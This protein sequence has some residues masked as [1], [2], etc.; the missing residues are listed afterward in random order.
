MKTTETPIELIVPYHRNN[1]THSSTQVDRIARSIKEY[2]FNQ[3][4]VCDKE[5]VIIVGH[6]RLEA[7]KQLGLKTVPVLTATLTEQQAREYRILDNKL[8]DQAEYDFEALNIELEELQ[9]DGFDLEGWGLEL[10]Q[11]E[12][13]IEEIESSEDFD[14][15][16]EE[17]LFVK[18]GDQIEIGS[19]RVFCGDVI[20]A[21]E[22]LFGMGGGYWDLMVTDPPYGVSYVGKTQDALVIENDDLEA[23]ELKIFLQERMQVAVRYGT[24]GASVYMAAP[25]GPLNEIFQSVLGELGILRQ[26]LI[27]LKDSM[28]MGRSD[29]H[30]KHE[31]ILYGWMPGAAHKPVM[32]RTKTTVWEFARPKKSEQHPTMKPVPLFAEAILNSSVRG[33]LV[34]DM[35][36]GSGTTIIAAEETGRIACGCELSPSYAQGI[37]IRYLKFCKGKDKPFTCKI[38]GEDITSEMLNAA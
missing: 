6:A 16:Q 24:K 22:W 18:V 28:V 23:D 14:P 33:D 38:N 36:L 20:D 35:F 21:P 25:P 26:T 5:G 15:A 29:Y 4:I 31:P 19:H 1:K 27:W 32:D 7:A 2:G 34:F 13:D 9:I 12:A 11:E 8:S 37:I 10:F 17:S 3:P 30:Y